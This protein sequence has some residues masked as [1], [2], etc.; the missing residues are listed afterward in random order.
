[1]ESLPA[2]LSP[3]SLCKLSPTDYLRRCTILNYDRVRSAGFAGGFVDKEVESKGVRSEDFV[4][5]LL[6]IHMLAA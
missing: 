1:M 6:S 2:T 4:A 5:T 3:R